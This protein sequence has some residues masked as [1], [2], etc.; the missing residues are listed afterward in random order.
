MITSNTSIAIV[1][2]FGIITAISQGF[3]IYAIIH[4][5]GKEDTSKEVNMTANF[6][7]LEVKLDG[8]NQRIENINRNVEKSDSKLDEIS[9]RLSRTDERI[10]TLFKYSDDFRKRLDRLE[11]K[12]K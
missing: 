5:K 9:D 3:A 6:T 11:G 10:N 2:I 8:V 1:V 4:S 12:E 7:R